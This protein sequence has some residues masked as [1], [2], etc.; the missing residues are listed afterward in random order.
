LG[1]ADT[2]SVF[3]IE[4]NFVKGL[5]MKVKTF[6]T[7]LKGAALFAPDCMGKQDILIA[8]DKVA[9]INS[10]IDVPANWEC[11]IVELDGKVTVPGFIDGHVH[12]I[13]GG[14]EGGFATRTGEVQL[15]DIICAG[16]TTVIGCLGTD[17]TTRHMTSLLAKA[18]GLEIE[19]VSSY[20]Y[21]GS[22]EVPTNTITRNVRDDIV[23]I[24]KVI[25]CGEIAISDHRSAQPTREQ[26]VSLAAECRVG[27]LL[28]GKAGVLHL[29][30]GDGE[31][32]L[33]YL[34]DIV[35]GGEIPITQFLPTHISRNPKLLKEGVRFAIR[36]GTIDITSGFISIPSKRSGIKPSDAVIYCL[37]KNVPLSNITMS[38]DG[39]GSMPSFDEKGKLI[40]LEVARMDTLY[41]EIRDLIT[42]QSLSIEDAIRLVTENPAKFFKLYPQK[43]CIAVG[44]DA[45]IV[46]LNSNY[47]ICDVIAKGKFMIRNNEQVKFGTFEKS[48]RVP[49]N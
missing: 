48:K 19:G 44:S 47:N 23:I 40:G 38:S 42:A 22:Y 28:S 35:E 9:A 3:P 41:A 20:I 32:G 6:F 30:L 11:T 43:G 27:G 2:T 26:I 14:G 15:G 31:N 21:T 29:H 17:G 18:N 46:V 45:D 25:G 24:D 13:G 49:N 10:R 36:G 33:K 34:F 7:L 12:L 1:D 4:Q 37:N 5:V 8:G 16:V 39:N